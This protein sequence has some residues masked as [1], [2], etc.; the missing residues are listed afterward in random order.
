M[1]ALAAA[2]AGGPVTLHLNQDPAENHCR[3]AVDVLF[4]SV[5][6]VYG[7]GVLAV[8]LTGMGSDGLAGCRLIREQGGT[9]LA[10]DQATS[11]VW[12]MPGSVAEAGLAH[13]VL[14]L[15]AMAQEIVR[16]CGRAAPAADARNL[17]R[18]VV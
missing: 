12:G 9:V 2:R 18:M 7:S 6:R 13:K 16:I 8:V 5:A 3:P 1:E 14:P 11:T 4:R 10:Q 15:G 17:A